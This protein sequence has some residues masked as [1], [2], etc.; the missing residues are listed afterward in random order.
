MQ[1]PF[2]M[3]RASESRRWCGP[4]QCRC[5]ERRARTWLPRSSYCPA[6][7]HTRQ[8]ALEKLAVDKVQDGYQ[9]D[10]T[11]LS[12]RLLIRRVCFR[13]ASRAKETGFIGSNEWFRDF[14]TAYQTGSDHACWHRSAGAQ[15]ANESENPA[16]G[17]GAFLGEAEDRG[18]RAS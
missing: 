5:R 9:H 3:A 13:T 8:C 15:N 6:A 14:G 11:P 18:P 16:W 12:G 17:S 2:K 10:R 4:G 7:A 1:R